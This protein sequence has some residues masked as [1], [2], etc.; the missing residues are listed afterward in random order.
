[1]VTGIT[2]NIRMAYGNMIKNTNELSND[3]IP[4]INYRVK[5]LVRRAG[6]VFF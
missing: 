4:R 1:M 3:F 2:L 6:R 5:G